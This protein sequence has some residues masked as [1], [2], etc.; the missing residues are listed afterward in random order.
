MEIG[1]NPNKSQDQ[2]G[3]D[4]KKSQKKFGIKLGSRPAS[5]LVGVKTWARLTGLRNDN[6]KS[7]SPGLCVAACPSGSPSSSRWRGD[8][9]ERSVVE[10]VVRFGLA[11]E[12]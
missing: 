11:F 8:S 12:T 7:G 9:A 3:I 1:I 2:F 5:P 10:W 4:P 6:S